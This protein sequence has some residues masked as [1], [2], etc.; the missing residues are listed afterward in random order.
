MLIYTK[1]TLIRALLEISDR[2]WIEN[3]RF[4]NAGGVGNTLE[5][6]LG[7]EENN[8]P[9]PNAAE[10]ELKCQRIGTAS[11]TTLFHAE[12]SPRALRIVPSILLPKYGWKHQF[13]GTRYPD[14]EKS[15]RQTVNSVGT[16]RGF[17][18]KIDDKNRRLV[19][20][21]N[22]S[23]VDASHAEWLKQVEQN[24]GLGELNPIPY[25][26][27]DDLA[28]KARTKLLNCFYVKAQVRRENH[29]EYY[30]YAE[31]YKCSDFSFDKFLECVRRGV[32]FV[33]FDARTRHNHGTKFR[34]KQRDNVMENLYENVERIR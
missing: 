11:L 13:A 5:D 32:L 30:H 8:L 21:F 1:E 10:W 34:L 14:D 19:I 7:I 27:F 4:G 31:I 6:L 2:G 29:K 25:W 3:R 23:A 33:D 18:L 22:S 24:A 26:G 15:F 17:K 9:I 16:D 20:S 28:S 12:P